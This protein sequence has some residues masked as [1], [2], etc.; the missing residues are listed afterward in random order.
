MAGIEIVFQIF[1][2]FKSF[3]KHI[4]VGLSGVAIQTV[5]SISVVDVESMAKVLKGCTKYTHK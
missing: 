5:L 2:L 1:R 3:A 4:V